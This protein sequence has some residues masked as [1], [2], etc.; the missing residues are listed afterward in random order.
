MNV[1]RERISRILEPREIPLTFQTA[2]I[3]AVLESILGI[4][5][6]SVMPEP[7]YLKLMTVSNFVHLL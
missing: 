6:S 1:T 2:V 3:C 4:E 7:R 5:P